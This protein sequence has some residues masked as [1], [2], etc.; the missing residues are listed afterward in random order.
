MV[1][2][3]RGADLGA[4]PRRQPELDGDDLDRHVVAGGEVVRAVDDRGRPAADGGAE[5]VAAE[6]AAVVGRVMRHGWG[7]ST[8]AATF[9][10]GR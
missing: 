2:A 10:L 5:D 6:D 3:A 1:Q 7:S 9:P 8:M 4:H